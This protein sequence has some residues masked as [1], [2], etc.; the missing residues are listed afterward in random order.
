M[1]NR[2]YLP[3]DHHRNQMTCLDLE[4]YSLIN[5]KPF[6][7]TSDPLWQ[8]RVIADTHVYTSS[9]PIRCW[10]IFHGAAI[11]F[12]ARHLEQGDISPIC[13]G[14]R[15][16]LANIR[17]ET[18]KRALKSLFQDLLV[19]FCRIISICLLDPSSICLLSIIMFR[20]LSDQID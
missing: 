8:R 2:L 16:L 11:I 17:I 3:L 10:L 6:P 12:G 19:E 7:N 18:E 9:N 1:I 20:R 13:G 4:R 14:G 15:Y 5:I